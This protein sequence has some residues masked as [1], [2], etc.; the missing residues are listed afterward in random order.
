MAAL[1]DGGFVVLWTS[2][3]SGGPDSGGTSVQGQRFDAGGMAQDDQFEVN[4]FAPV[5]QDSP[6]VTSL[7]DGSFV[8]VWNSYGESGYH[9]VRGQ[10]YA[11]GGTPLAG[12][13][14]INTEPTNTQF[15]APSVA[16][17]ADGGF[18][19]V[20]Q[21]FASSGTDSSADSIQ[22]QRFDADGTAMAGEFQINWTTI[23]PQ[24][25]P[26]VAALDDGGFIVTW[27]SESSSGPYCSRTLL[28]SQPRTEENSRQADHLGDIH[29]SGRRAEETKMV[30]QEAGEQLR[31]DNDHEHVRKPQ[32][33]DRVTDG[34]DDDEPENTRGQSMAW[35]LLPSS[36]VSATR[37]QGPEDHQKPASDVGDEHTL[38]CPDCAIH[39]PHELSLQCYSNASGARYGYQYHDA[40]MYRSFPTVGR[41][42]F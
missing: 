10:R 17:L 7:A 6:A 23:G 36:Q 26:S 1:A 24:L 35:D 22:G 2:E 41:P 19:V 15:L 11:A 9:D 25:Y 40:H 37:E 34:A 30:Y 39:R 16:A 14:Q 32:T 12:E 5:N 18:V 31:S 29:R 33:R 3:R 42:L 38:R 20:W 21:S 28:Q 27:Q 8:A 4:S 13:L